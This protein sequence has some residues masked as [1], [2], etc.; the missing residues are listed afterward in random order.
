MQVLFFKSIRPPVPGKPSD[1]E[2]GAPGA[3]EQGEAAPGS[4]KPIHE[5]LRDLADLAEKHAAGAAPAGDDGQPAG[6]AP[7]DDGGQGGADQPGGEGAGADEGA[8]Q[9]GAPGADEGAD[10]SGSEYNAE[11]V[12][13]GSHVAFAAGA[14][15]GAGE[16]TAVGD[17]GATVKDKSGREHRIRWDEITGLQGGGEQEQEQEQRE[18]GAGNDDQPPQGNQPP[19][20][21]QPPAPGS[22]KPPFGGK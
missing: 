1:G 5:H 12:P 18:E 20:G 8:G 10:G 15:M 7:G 16:V 21:E 19:Q 3:G 6:D 4:D 17:D 22:K 9:E 2:G 14:F 11:S 13:V